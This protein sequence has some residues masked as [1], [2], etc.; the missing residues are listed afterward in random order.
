MDLSEYSLVLHKNFTPKTSYKKTVDYLR[1]KTIEGFK[2]HE[3]EKSALEGS[4]N[5]KEQQ[6]DVDFDDFEDSTISVEEEI[7]RQKEENVRKKN[8]KELS[9]ENLGFFINNVIKDETNLRSKLIAVL[10]ARGFIFEKFDRD[11]IPVDISFIYPHINSRQDLDLEYLNEIL[12]STDIGSIVKGALKV[13]K[14]LK[15]YDEKQQFKEI[16]KFR[17]YEY[18]NDIGVS[19]GNLDPFIARLVRAINAVNIPTSSACDGHHILSYDGH[20]DNFDYASGNPGETLVSFADNSDI[21]LFSFLLNE[22]YKPKF[23]W[24]FNQTNLIIENSRKNVAKMYLE[25]QGVAVFMEKKQK[26]V[27]YLRHWLKNYTPDYRNDDLENLIKKSFPFKNK[28]KQG[29]DEPRF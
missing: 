7:S 18:P 24:S 11:F 17:R 23:K 27:K 8:E 21:T 22:Y 12:E 1:G 13:N 6:S 3:T 29:S 28:L 5:M 10:K 20:L 9:I 19:V 25:I 26:I 14:R 16:F 4:S 15:N 2:F